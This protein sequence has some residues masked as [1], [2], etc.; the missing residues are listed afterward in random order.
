MVFKFFLTPYYFPD[1]Y[2]PESIALAEG[3]REIGH[4]V[5]GNID[6]WYEPG[7]NEYLIQE[8]NLDDYDVAIYDYKYLY[9]S[10]K[11]TI[12]EID[13]GKKNVLI[14]RNDWIY[15][16]EWRKDENTYKVFDII[17]AHNM[18]D[19]VKYPPN[20]MPW[21]IGYTKRIASYITEEVPS[22]KPKKIVHNF[23]VPHNLR[24]KLLEN[25]KL[26]LPDGIEL[27]SNQTE[28]LN[29]KGVNPEL[30]EIDR[31]YK[32]A[33]FKRHDPKYYKEINDNLI[34]CAFGGYYEYVP[35]R[36]QPYSLSD[37]VFRKGTIYLEKIF[38]ALGRDSS[39]LYFV[40]QYDSFRMWETF[41][42][43]TCP[44]L[45][46]FDYWNLKIPVKPIE[47]VHYVGIK[48][49]DCK[50][51][52]EFIADS[53][54]DELHTIGINGRKWVSENYSPSAVAKRLIKWLFK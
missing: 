30:E 11:W 29:G 32:K 42:A 27:S 19:F 48:S 2:S 20:V 6:Y 24:R 33:T 28:N 4:K 22:E 44:L 39:K 36:T 25:I 35:Y 13:H 45:L 31:I 18:L 51:A 54:V 46:D 7:S 8:N 37:K 38:R 16:Q 49:F 1:N 34:T 52:M 3:F 23:R 9:H 47:K 17:L 43:K 41:Y 5:I 53:S 15:R 26:Q 40:F 50:E 14:D 21:A 12:A 10:K